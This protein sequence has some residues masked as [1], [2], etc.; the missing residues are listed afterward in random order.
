MKVAKELGLHLKGVAFHTGSGGVDYQTYIRSLEQVK[1]IFDDGKA[2]GHNRMDLVDIGGGF[3]GILPGSG[4]N[5][6]EV[7]PNI[8]QAID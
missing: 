3:T 7:A 2:M 1:Q 5:F 8:R 4:K 6:E